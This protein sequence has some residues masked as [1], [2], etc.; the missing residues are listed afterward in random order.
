[1]GKH[2]CNGSF[3]TEELNLMVLAQK[4]LKPID[5]AKS[6]KLS[7][8]EELTFGRFQQAEG[9]EMGVINPLGIEMGISNPLMNNDASGIALAFGRSLD[10]KR[11]NSVALRKA[12]AK[13]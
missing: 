1:V 12:I 2:G 9:V 7:H 5:E 4:L 13:K 3:L 11:I 6:H 8:E 10:S